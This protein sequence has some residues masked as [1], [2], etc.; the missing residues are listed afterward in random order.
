MN[1]FDGYIVGISREAF[2]ISFK[3]EYIYNMNGLFFEKRAKMI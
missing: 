3:Q 1:G 2:C